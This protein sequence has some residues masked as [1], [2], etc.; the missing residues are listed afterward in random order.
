MVEKLLTRFAA[1]EVAELA[2]TFRVVIIGGARQVGKSTLAVSQ[3]GRRAQQV[4]SL[5][6]A[7][8][9]AAATDDPRGFV[10]ALPHGAVVD[11]F[12]RAGT[13]F[14]LAVKRR[15]DR[16]R[17][18]G[19][20]LLTGSANYLAARGVTET[21][22]G[23]SGRL[24]LW[25]LSIG[26]RLGRRENFI[27]RA[28]TDQIG[29]PIG[30]T[31]N[32]SPSSQVLGW[33]TEGGFPEIVSGGLT[34]IRRARW[35]DAYVADVVNREALRPLADVRYEHEL[36]RVLTALAARVTTP[37]VVSDLAR[38]LDLDRATVT[39]Y[40]A[41]LEALY[42]VHLLPPFAPSATTAAKRRPVIHLTDSGL[43]AHLC[44]VTADDLG[45]A[46][47][48]ALRGPLV[49][50]FAVGEILKEN[51]WRADPV[52]VLHYRD[53]AQ[54][55]VDAVLRERRTGRLVGIEVKA[56]STP[57]AAH[58]KH[59]RYLRDKVGDRFAAGLVLHLGDQLLD[60]G[61]GIRAVPISTL[62]DSTA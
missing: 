52:E 34:S 38:D 1:E 46:S 20:L 32:L 24:H 7:A 49:E 13:G 25:P 61:D 58:A 9:L 42:L 41:L 15:V 10:D 23:R 35:F 39:N 6:D 14:L 43:T 51:S 8:L 4:Y 19:Q 54:R 36:R 59:L 26:E 40:V 33:L 56:T 60:L 22:A 21:L 31:P 44:G 12:Q 55:E 30:S 16:D 11:E 45:A 48:H 27:D 5:D 29:S 17:S 28:F 37:L 3:L 47:A 50:S 57:L 62:W 18:K 53:A 2:A